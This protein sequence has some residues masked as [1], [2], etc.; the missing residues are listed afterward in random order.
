MNARRT[1]AGVV[2][3]GVTAMFVTGCRDQALSAQI[4]YTSHGVPHIQANGLRGLGYGVGYV[5]GRANLCKLAADF[6]TVAGER[7]RYYGA[8]ARTPGLGVVSNGYPRFC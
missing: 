5:Q 8:D 2:A 7:S 4:R 3:V 1:L 6:L